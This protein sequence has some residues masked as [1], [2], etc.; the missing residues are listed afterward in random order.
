M[1]DKPIVAFDTSAINQLSDDPDCAAL[2]PRIRAGFHVRLSATGVGELIATPDAPRRSKLVALCKQLLHSADCIHNAYH[3]LQ[4]LIREFE[5]SED[6]DWQL[7]DVR[8]QQAED[9]LRSGGTFN[10]SESQSVR[11]ENRE[12]KRKFEEF[13]K[14]FNP[15]YRQAFA[16]RGATRPANLS[17]SVDRLRKTGSFAKMA[18][19]LYAYI[20]D[21]DPRR[22][23]PPALAVERFLRSCPPFHAYLLGL[24]A[25]RY[26]RNLKPSQGRSMK[27]GALDTSMA[28][29]LPYCHVFV[30]NDRGMENCFKEIG[31]TARLPAEVVP[32]DC[33]RQRLVL[34]R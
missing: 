30:T 17:E 10:D 9:D 19:V 13:Y 27:A 22:D 6:F 4:M 1:D 20:S 5:G 23:P 31:V 8:F 12:A 25:A 32:Y 7:V 29:C 34:G 18:S 15:L 3:L 2:L 33:F 24:C 26:A 16:Q 21:R 14:R 28:A 11:E